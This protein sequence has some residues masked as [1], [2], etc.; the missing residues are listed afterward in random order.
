MHEK[1]AAE[2]ATRRYDAAAAKST[3]CNEVG[4]LQLAST[5]LKSCPA[6]DTIAMLILLLQLPPIFLTLV[7]ALFASLTFMPPSGVTMTSVFSLFDV[8]QGSAG[9]P[10]LGTMI[11][12]DALCL[13]GWFCRWNWARNFA[14]DLAQVQI[15]ITLGGGNA[16][17]AG[18]VNSVCVA[19]VLLL[20]LL[21]S[22]CVR[23]FIF[24]H[25]LSGKF[26]ANEHVTHVVQ[27]MPQDVDFGDTPKSPSWSR[28]L[29]AIHIITQAGIAIIR[30]NVAS[31]QASSTSKISKRA[32]TEASAGVQNNQDISSFESGFMTGVA[33]TI[34]VPTAPTPGLKDSKDRA[35][36]AKKRRRQANQVRS[37]Q[38]FW[39]ALASTKVNALR[40]IEISRPS[41]KATTNTAGQNPDTRSEETQV[42]ITHVDCSSIKFEAINLSLEHNDNGSEL[43][44]NHKPFFVRINGAYWT[45]TCIC[46][47]GMDISGTLW[48]GEISGLAPDCTY[49]CSFVQEDDLEI[50]AVMV[51]TPAVLD[52]DQT[53]A[54]SLL[55]S[56]S[57]RRS[58]RPSS[59]TTTIRQSIIT[60]E[61]KLTDAKGRVSRTRR[62]HKAALSKLEREVE[63]FN[64]RLKSSS[65]DT[66]QRQKL[67][68][69]ERSMKQN[70]DATQSISA[71]LDDLSTIP[72]EGHDEYSSKKEA[73]DKQCTLLAAANES[74]ISAKSSAN[75]ELTTFTEDLKAIHRQRER[76]LARQT[77][78]NEQH[79][80]ITQANL[81]GLNEKERKAAET[82]ATERDHSRIEAEYSNQ[83][84]IFQREL[85]SFS[86]RIQQAKQESQVLESQM[87]HLQQ[88]NMSASG[89]L[90]P[91]GILPG[92]NPTTRP[93][94]TT[95]SQGFSS[96]HAMTTLPAPL[97]SESA[98]VSPF[99]PYSKP[100]AHQQDHIANFGTNRA[101]S[102]SN[103]SGGAGS[104]YSA[105]FEDADPIPPMHGVTKFGAEGKRKGSGGSG[106]GSPAS[107]VNTGA[108][109][110]GGL[111]SPLRPSA[112]ATLP[113]RGSPGQG[114]W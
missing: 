113:G 109:G 99:L 53:S 67:L 96:N 72:E 48:T 11:A 40:E 93:A 20:H 50:A 79:D 30:R 98:H 29:F 27:Y 70:E 105:D 73:Y 12:G 32:D 1:D 35:T 81:Q 103:R 3:A 78:L 86:L 8:F 76:L 68:Q 97:S 87:M 17:M 75:S 107:A 6:Y 46:T 44:P 54:L 112:M 25:I 104:N 42:R 21:R 13:G 4:T 88:N 108:I 89:P 41:S 43:S 10:S 37:R 102:A 24:H 60:T 23:Q 34:D 47:S 45:S 14:L 16:G 26:L 69:A 2:G 39:A 9:T 15:A 71:A 51:K 85:A 77:R 22:R 57:I 49:T 83:F 58:Q 90:T 65:D 106:T 33:G 82:L 61:A 62:S 66:K 31:S 52:K 111:G 19:V 59:P 56:P 80:R 84:G 110:I 92:T 74:L 5:I 114:T 91:E 18:S 64:S 36:S 55:S 28:S 100:L 38:P 63:F 95:L 7:Q 101:R 94:Q